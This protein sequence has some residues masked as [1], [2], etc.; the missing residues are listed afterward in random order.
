M[1]HFN[2]GSGRAVQKRTHHTL[3]LS[4][5][6]FPVNLPMGKNRAHLIEVVI[7]GSGGRVFLP[8]IQ[9]FS[10]TLKLTFYFKI[11]C[12]YL[13]HFCKHCAQNCVY[14]EGMGVFRDAKLALFQQVSYGDIKP[15]LKQLQCKLDL[16]LMQP[17]VYGEQ[18]ASWSWTALEFRS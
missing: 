18:L 6:L 13:H 9:D 4:T 5:R 7:Q 11:L 1:S 17:R 10:E 3:D 14:I 15:T 16:E 12:L 8:R 2:L